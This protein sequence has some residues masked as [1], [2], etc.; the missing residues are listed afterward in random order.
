MMSH[1][2]TGWVGGSP[3][4][5]CAWCYYLRVWLWLLFI[6]GLLRALK[7]VIYQ[8]SD[9]TKPPVQT[10]KVWLELFKLAAREKNSLS[11]V[12]LR[13]RDLR[14]TQRQGHSPWPAQRQSERRL[15]EHWRP[16]RERAWDRSSVQSRK[17]GRKQKSSTTDGDENCIKRSVGLRGQDITL[18]T[19]KGGSK[20][21]TQPQKQEDT[22]PI[23]EAEKPIRVLMTHWI[24]MSSHWGLREKDK[25]Y[26]G[27]A[28][29]KLAGKEKLMSTMSWKLAVKWAEFC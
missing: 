29:T 20:K 28:V 11:C 25:G 18:P 9:S 15:V 10:S 5:V 1:P 22:S 2:G 23:F 26:T 4:Y 14:I 21:E 19:P 6:L 13:R 8:L 27:L 12:Y 7:D 3:L 24:W 17:R 16:E